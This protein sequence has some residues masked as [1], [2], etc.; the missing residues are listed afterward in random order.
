MTSY[1]KM[2]LTEDDADEMLNAADFDGDGQ[3]NYEEFVN[4]FTV[5]EDSRSDS[6]KIG[7]KSC[8][9]HRVVHLVEDSLLL[10][11]Q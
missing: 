5:W 9:D 2:K 3:I 10:T 4:M 7:G 6:L 11:L 1:G 8:R